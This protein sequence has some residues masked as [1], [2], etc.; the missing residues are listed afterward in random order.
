MEKY[1]ENNYGGWLI[2]GPGKVRRGTALDDLSAS[3][4][5]LAEAREDRCPRP[6]HHHGVGPGMS[7]AEE[8]PSRVRPTEWTGEKVQEGAVVDVTKIYPLQLPL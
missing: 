4:F 3:S 8:R 5:Q 7:R 1:L 6:P 2:F